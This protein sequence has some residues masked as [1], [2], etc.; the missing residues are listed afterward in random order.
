MEDDLLVDLDF[1]RISEL[2]KL[3]NLLVGQGAIT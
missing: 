1:E 2:E 3:T